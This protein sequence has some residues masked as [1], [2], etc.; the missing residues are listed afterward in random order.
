MKVTA[1][2]DPSCPFGFTAATIRTR[3]SRKFSCEGPAHLN[4][5]PIRDKQQVDAG[6]TETLTRNTC[7]TFDAVS[8]RSSD[9]SDANRERFPGV[10]F[11]HQPGEQATRAEALTTT[12]TT[13]EELRAS[14]ADAKDVQADQRTRESLQEDHL[15]RE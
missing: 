14:V 13:V 7:T 8:Q 9:G 4:R 1:Q 5:Q 2:V 15:T 11:S 3:A 10:P 12:V 6:N